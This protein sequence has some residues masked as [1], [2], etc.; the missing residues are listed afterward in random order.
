MAGSIIVGTL[1]V[2]C[3]GAG[4][5]RREP[6]GADEERLLSLVPED[7]RGSCAF[8]ES[9]LGGVAPNVEAVA[10]HPRALA[11]VFC[12]WEPALGSQGSIHMTYLLFPSKEA[13]YEDYSEGILSSFLETDCVPGSASEFTYLRGGREAGHVFCISGPAITWTD[14][15]TFVLAHASPMY[16]RIE[17]RALYDWWLDRQ[18]ADVTPSIDVDAPRCV[19]RGAS[20]VGTSGDDVLRGTEGADVIVGLGGDD[21]ILGL[22]A[23]DLICGGPGDD[24]IVGGDASDILSGGLGD[25]ALDGGGQLFDRV[26][27]VEADGPVE[28]DLAVGIATG[29][30]DDTLEG[31]RQVEGTPFD[32]LI[33]G[34]DELNNLYGGGGSDLLDGRGGWDWLYGG[35]GDDLLRGGRGRDRLEGED[36]NDELVGG[37]DADRE[38]G[39]PGSDACAETGPSAERGCEA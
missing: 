15:E 34:D 24:R 39:G 4:S 1:L 19:G 36:G 10:G 28:A 6:A 23:R 33:R 11:G 16:G 30:G 2:A 17:A 13:M 25:D 27:F 9:F 32:D 38:W 29:E 31:L 7:V 12:T 20:I 26:S 8:E 37:P 35:A 21:L 5:V 14:D 3:V 22:G 18:A